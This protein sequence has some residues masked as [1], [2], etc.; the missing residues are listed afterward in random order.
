MLLDGFTILLQPSHA[1]SVSNLQ[2]GQ[3]KSLRSEF[4]DDAYSFVAEPLISMSKVLI[5]ATKTAMGK[6]DK[7]FSWSKFKLVFR[8]DYRTI[9]GAFE[10]FEVEAHV[11]RCSTQIAVGCFRDVVPQLLQR[12]SLHFLIFL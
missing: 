7:C 11:V 3:S 2:I 1:D 12:I 6:F 9:V 4:F 10:N 5:C 8:L